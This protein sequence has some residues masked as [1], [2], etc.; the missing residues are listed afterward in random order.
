M[1]NEN[2]ISSLYMKEYKVIAVYGSPR[3]GG[4]TDKLLDGFIEGLRDCGMFS[5]GKNLSSF[6]ESPILFPDDVDAYSKGRKQEKEN[7]ETLNPDMV[8]Q[9]KLSTETLNQDSPGIKTGGL[10][11]SIEKIILSN[12][13]VSPCRECRHCSIDGKCIVNDEMQQIY[14]KMMECD[15]L[16]IASPIFFTSVSGQ[17]KIFI[18]RFQRFWALKYELGKNTISKI[19]RKGILISCAG[20]KPPDIFDCTKKITRA[21]FDVLFIKYYADFLYNNIDFKGD[22][23]K[24]PDDLKRVYDFAKTGEFI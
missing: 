12:L 21:L 17:L 24:D 9:K 20:S 15:L 10:K 7:P 22:I 19:G 8:N 11:L 3:R 5:T 14:P 6:T 23:L 4:N 16:L 1:D 18:D 2:N 13:R